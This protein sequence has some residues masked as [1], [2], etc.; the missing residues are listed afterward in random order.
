MV[1]SGDVESSRQEAAKCGESVKASDQ[2]LGVVSLV[3]A[4]VVCAAINGA[5]RDSRAQVAEARVKSAFDDSA[6][7]MLPADCRRRAVAVRAQHGRTV[8]RSHMQRL[9]LA[10]DLERRR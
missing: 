9:L 5:T 3:E 7:A 1:A 10:E 4:V 2:V 8:G 6:L